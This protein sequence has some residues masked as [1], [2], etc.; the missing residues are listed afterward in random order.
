MLWSFDGRLSRP[1]YALLTAAI[2][3]SQHLVALLI[4]KAHG[5]ALTP[6]WRFWLMPL[7]SFVTHVEV[8]N[9]LNVVILILAVLAAWAIAA[10]AFRRAADAGLSP[11]IAAFALAPISQ[12]PIF[13]LLS[14]VPTSAAR[15]QPATAGELSTPEWHAA[16]QGVL[17]GIGLT[18]AAV[19]LG[20]LVFGSY[21]YG[22]F[23][24]APFVTGALTAYAVNRRQDIGNGRTAKLVLAATSLSGLALVMAALEGAICIV[25]A[26][27]LGIPLALIG[28]LLGRAI[29]LRSP[30]GPGQTAASFALMP[31]IFVAEVLL[32]PLTTFSINESIVVDASAARIWSVLIDHD[33][34]NEPVA[35]IFKLGLAYP[36]RGTVIG[37]GVGAIRLGEF[38]TGTAIERI[39]RW[40]PH[41]TLAFAVL[42]DVP[43]MRELS[44]Y[45]HVHAPHA[46]GY[47]TTAEASYDLRPLPDGRTQI[48]LR[49]SHILKLE[50]VFYWLPMARGVVQWNNRRVLG[51]I[52]RQAEGG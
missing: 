15:R 40:V 47:F 45:T 49:T 18:L 11:W 25:M 33:M 13:M 34:T 4:A 35:P 52:K 27:P 32:P 36:R 20:T 38:S 26:A 37:E 24:A 3:F 44:P 50:P 12:I 42:R 43:A 51:H 6:D 14:I 16:A 48:V 23:V 41:Q 31:L 5:I 19:A 9:A 7:R 21:G 22:V 30:P 17:L 28:G 2:F 1:A 46:V 8:S 10:A 39:T 29:A